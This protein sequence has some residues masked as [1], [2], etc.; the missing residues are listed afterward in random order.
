[1]EVK[2]PNFADAN[3]VGVSVCIY[4]KEL[5]FRKMLHPGERINLDAQSEIGHWIHFLLEIDKDDDLHF[6]VDAAKSLG[7]SKLPANSSVVEIS[8]KLAQF[9]GLNHDALA[10]GY[11]VLAKENRPTRGLIPALSVTTSVG[12]EA[13]TLDGAS[14]T[15]SGSTYA[16]LKWATLGDGS[17]R[18]ELVASQPIMFDDDF[19]QRAEK[20]LVSGFNRF[21][22]A[23]PEG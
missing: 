21:V 3:L 19:L 9:V 6:Q 23:M 7:P 10:I 13:L 15:I 14:L 18:I 4:T 2:L 17:L 22:L 8:E 12:G 16:L 20:L 11:F 5:D 1:M